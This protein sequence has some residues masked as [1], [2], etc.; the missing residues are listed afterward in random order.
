MNIDYGV[1]FVCVDYDASFNLTQ[2]SVVNLPQIHVNSEEKKVFKRKS[3]IIFTVGA[4][5]VQS[6]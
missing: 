2:F 4:I 6:I 5:F 3:L 1:F